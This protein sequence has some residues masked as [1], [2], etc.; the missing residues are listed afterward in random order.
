MKPL[1]MV[2]TED[3]G[4]HVVA[5]ASCCF[6]SFVPSVDQCGEADNVFSLDISHP[7]SQFT[8]CQPFQMKL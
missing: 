2:K 6:P 3:P 4:I 1:L 7:W 5:D 8:L